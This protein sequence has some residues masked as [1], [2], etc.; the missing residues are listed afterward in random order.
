VTAQDF[1]RLSDWFADYCKTFYSSGD[2]DRKNIVLKEVHTGRVIENMRALVD[3]LAM[4]AEDS[5]LAQTIALLHD[6]GRFLQY[7]RY[8]TFLDSASVNHGALGAQVIT[9]AGILS[10]LPLRERQIVVQSVK[11]HNAF[12]LPDLE[13]R[14]VLPFLK[15]IRDA[16]K[17]DIWRIFIEYYET[18]PEERPSAVGLG[19]SERNE[20]SGEIVACLKANRLASLS[21]IKTFHD[22][23]LMQ[24][25][26]V[27]D[28]NFSPSFRLL[29]E[30]NLVHGIASTL[31][32]TEEIAAGLAVVEEFVSEK[33]GLKRR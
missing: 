4:A 8:K 30:R 15:L 14:E 26:W 29:A 3:D 23:K 6:V 33:S 18:P 2:E 12:S 13:N 21:M 16:D 10:P 17:L 1:E 7:A 24:L 22:F 32:Q 9:D 11:F 28:L 31:P 20:Y 27:Y 19:L 25:S 5:F